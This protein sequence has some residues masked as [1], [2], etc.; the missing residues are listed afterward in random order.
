MVLRIALAGAL[1]AALLPVPAAVAAPFVDPLAPC[2]VAA[3]PDERQPVALTAHGFTPYALLDV[4]VDDVL[5]PPGPVAPQA[6]ANGDLLGGSIPAPYIPA[7]VRRFTLRVAEHANPASAALTSS[8][9]AALSV[10]QVPQRAS[11][12]A[13]VRFRGRGFTAPRAVWA[14]YV[15]AGISRK[16]VR[17]GAPTGQCGQFSRRVRQ[18]PFK[19]SP[20][21]GTWTIQ[22]DQ[23]RRYSATTDVL[24]RL[25]VKVNRTIRPR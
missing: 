7:G 22:F 25:T 14:H 9:V 1:A 3:Q 2:Y 12:G 5:Q 19:H 4:Y 10:E 17:I 8:R 21:V 16:S 18:F 15:Y 6:D 20:K 24:V 11:T 23:Q 13:R